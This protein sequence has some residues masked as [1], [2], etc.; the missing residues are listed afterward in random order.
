MFGWLPDERT[1][2]RADLVN[3][4]RK[5]TRDRWRPALHLVILADKLMDLACGRITRLM[6]FM[7]PRHGKSYLCS[8][9]FPA[10]YLINNPD[11]RVILTSY[12][13]S[14]AFTFSRRVREIV[15]E[16]GQWLAGVELA[17]DS[18]AVD[19]WDLKGHEGGLV[20]AGVGGPITGHGGDIVLVD[21]VIK[22]IAEANSRTY[23][24]A[25]WDWYASTLRTR[26]EPGAGLAI[27]MCLAKG[28]RVLM[29]DGTWKPI[30][31]INPGEEV[32]SWNGTRFVRQ[33]VTGVF[34][35]GIAETITVR[36][37]RH[38]ITVTPEH[39]F[40]RS[41]GF[42]S[43]EWVEARTLKPGD[44]ILT[45]RSVPTRRK[46]WLKDLRR[47]A[48]REEIWLLGY[49]WGDGWVTKH[50]RAN[51]G[52]HYAVCCA[53]ST[54]E[55]E[56][57]RLQA[58]L[59]RLTG[60][61]PY[62]TKCGYIRV[63]SNGGGRLL[64]NL[65]LFPGVR[66]PYKKLP[67]WVFTLRSS[68]KRAF[69]EG[70]L[71]ADGHKMPRCKRNVWRL[72]S[73]SRELVEDAR[74]LAL[75]CSVRPTRLR[76]QKGRSRP[77]H[78]REVKSWTAWSADFLFDNGGSG[79]RSWRIKS[80]EK[81]LALPVYDLRVSGTENFVAEGFVVHNT[82]WHH[83][84]LAGRLLAEMGS[85]GEQWEVLKLPAFAEEGDPLGRAAGE[86]LWPERY[87]KK[88][89]E[90]LRNTLGSFLFS[91]IYQQ[92][93]RRSEGNMFRREWFRYFREEG[94]CYALFKPGGEHRV[95]KTD[96]WLFQTV[97]PA[98][99][100]KETSDYFACGTWAVTPESDLLLVDMFRER[101]E[102]PKHKALMKA[103][104]A[105]YMPAFQG[106]EEKTF[107]LALIQDMRLEGLPVV[108]L[109]ADTDKVSRAYPIAARYEM[110]AVYHRQGAPW[111]RAYE[112]E[113]EDFPNGA[114]D[115]MVDCASYAAVV[116]AL[117]RARR[118]QRK[119]V[120]RATV[121]G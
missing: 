32:W 53:L 79:L 16:H 107:G 101:L 25:V 54:R 43:Y 70:L 77:P 31:H 84:D 113:L 98:A 42:H 1:L 22:N 9:L 58:G 12:G 119:G 87:D 34:P 7:P 114:H 47:Y 36:T 85:G 115:D 72:V 28:S 63:D 118:Q 111:L 109:K 21:D 48:T 35:Q 62:R 75:T 61:N 23:R 106:V 96:C 11:K 78:S 50:I 90:D 33:E 108:P 29:G 86:P 2:V 110:G 82:R 88:A 40:L 66:A 6:V 41:R 65:G 80:I 5:V 19:R 95:K 59:A 91:A 8:R 4:C 120:G 38:A 39:P 51:G 18:S 67:G 105:R 56:N 17:D 73:S 74:L 97:D 64:E 57:Q 89:L 121:I 93:P 99:T 49:L 20:A 102:T 71:A 68:D 3:F 24:E 117:D 104:Y 94:D 60:G 14:L 13:A 69:L 44:R 103:M 37:D 55:D 15:R 30:E 52:A 26:L 10:W 83:E 27:I 76:S 92:S 46:L 112:D 81:G 116:L 100:E 45:L